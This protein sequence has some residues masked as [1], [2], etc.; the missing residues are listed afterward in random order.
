M[1]RRPWLSSP[2]RIT[3]RKTQTK[4]RTV[5]PS[6]IISTKSIQAI[7]SIANLRPESSH[8]AEPLFCPNLEF[9]STKIPK[10]F[11]T[12]R[13]SVT[14]WT[15]KIESEDET[16]TKCERKTTLSFILS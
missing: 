14:D 6:I 5:Q 15:R 11:D 3:I 10:N 12:T 9:L 13:S 1:G 4:K 8:P 7:T 2:A 16:T